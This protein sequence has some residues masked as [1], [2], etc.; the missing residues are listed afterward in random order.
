VHDDDVR[1]TPLAVVG[2][3]AAG[4]MPLP[5][6]AVYAVMFLVHG[7]IHPVNP[8]D[9]TR[10]KGGEFVVGLITLALFVLITVSLLWLLNARRRW[11]FVILQ[12]AVLGT[13]IDF[14][15]DGTKGGPVISFLIILTSLAAVVLAFAPPA[16]EH[17]GQAPP[18][19]LARAY[20]RREA[21]AAVP[22]A[23]PLDVASE[24]AA[25]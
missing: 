25:P 23:V 5:F 1:D 15:V 11:P 24:V 13:A 19:L 2:A 16:W 6:L 14:L 8:P 4:L 9:V 20:G 21:R 18:R 12:L 3:V 17:L 10:T 7:S 22:D